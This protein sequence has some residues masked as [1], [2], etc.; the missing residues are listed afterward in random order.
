M[1][2][3][4]QTVEELLGSPDNRQHIGTSA[5]SRSGR[6]RTDPPALTMTGQEFE[7]GR[8]FSAIHLYN[9]DERPV[10]I[11]EQTDNLPSQLR[12]Q[13]GRIGGSRRLSKKVRI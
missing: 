10:G 3:E 1:I 4:E 8:S 12:R 7:W 13:S 9:D 5:M 6:D 11:R 2:C